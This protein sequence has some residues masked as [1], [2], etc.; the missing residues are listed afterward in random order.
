MRSFLGLAVAAL[1]AA[2]AGQKLPPPPPYTPD[3]TPEPITACPREQDAAKAAREA[4]LGAESPE[5]R[6]D[7]AYAAFAHGECERRQFDATTLEGGDV[8]L[9]KA[10]IRAV[11]AQFYTA[12]NLYQE[13][14]SYDVPTWAVGGRVRIGELYAAYAAKL[15]ASDPGPGIDDPGQQ[16]TWASQVEQL[17]RPYDSEA[18]GSY[19]AALEL[20]DRQDEAFRAE[21]A[22]ARWLR[23]ACDGLAREDRSWASKYVSCGR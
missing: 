2:C 23:T 11:K 19:A 15:R 17:A 6:S 14:V 12:F 10:S 21:A 16:Q 7:A 1:I 3:T 8:E 18:A 4:L 20:A 13:A 5:R 9:F 22:V